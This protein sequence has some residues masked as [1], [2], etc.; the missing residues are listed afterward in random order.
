MRKPQ[1]PALIPMFQPCTSS[2]LR[3]FP[4][5]PQEGTCSGPG[6]WEEVCSQAALM[7][8]KILLTISVPAT[9]S[10]GISEEKLLLPL[11]DLF[12]QCKPYF[13]PR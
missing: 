8:L 6:V 11:R 5:M 4:E 3:C 13:P 12:I 1:A 2:Y 10:P 9:G 7:M